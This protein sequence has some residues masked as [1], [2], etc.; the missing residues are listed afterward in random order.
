MDILGQKRE[1]FGN[2]SADKTIVSGMPILRTT[3]SMPSINNDGDSISFLTDLLKSLVGSESIQEIVTDTLIYSINDIESEIKKELKRE[4]KSIVSCGVN[5][6]IP[7][8]IK[9]D[10]IKIRA[11]QI[12]YFGLMFIRPTSEAGQLI[13]NDLTPNLLNSTDFNTFLYQTIQNDGQT[14]TWPQYAGS[15]TSILN[16]TFRSND[17]SGIDPNNTITIKPSP[18]FNGSL[19]DLNNQFIDSI[20][21]FNTEKLVSQIVDVIFGTVSRNTNK[22]TKQL[23][24]EESINTVVK[25]FINLDKDAIVDDSTF[26][27]SNVEK[28]LN[29][30]KAS[31]RKKGEKVFDTSN[32]FA[33]EIPLNDLKEMDIN[34]SLAANDVLKK[35]ELTKSLNK[36][37]DGI[38]AN[39]TNKL[40]EKALKLEFIQ[41]IINVLI[42]AIVI[43]IMLPKI[44]AIFL[45]NFKIIYGPNE[46]FN[47]PIDFIKKNRNLI[48]SVTKKIA[49]IIIGALLQ[50]VLK[51][52]TR[53][54][55]EAIKKKLEDK[56]KSTLKQLLSLVGGVS[57]DIIR[58]I[59]NI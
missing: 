51:E 24:L 54:V 7:D 46:T 47:D 29:E 48:R 10:G 14:Q 40:D 19:T 44:I 35:S 2:V 16:F 8:D 17:V 34:V 36:M 50:A 1:I 20:S 32:K 43:G 45:I 6:S 11:N 9:N 4:L 55:S 27:F 41:E 53:L 56:A 3:S 31:M 39:A 58:K 38:A 21:I 25:K 15:T 33:A 5:P 59:N 42:Q 23:E 18:N 22:S 30:Y 12:D 13:F 57:Q 49:G 28:K 52:V 37:S 26:D